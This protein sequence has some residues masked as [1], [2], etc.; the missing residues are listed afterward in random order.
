MP[1]EA[2]EY[3]EAL[4]NMG[5]KVACRTGKTG[6]GGI[7]ADEMGLGKTL[8]MITLFLYNKKNGEKKS[9]LVVCRLLLYITRKKKSTALRLLSKLGSLPVCRQSRKALNTEADVY[10]TSY[11]LLKRDL[12]LYAED[13]TFSVCVID[14]A[15]LH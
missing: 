8:Q 14:E 13:K 12:K 7:L 1:A 3:S 2:A 9:A 5:A 10:I 15:Q 4:S 11:D 6:F